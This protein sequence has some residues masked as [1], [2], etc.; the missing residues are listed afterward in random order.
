MVDY[1]L[2]LTKSGLQRP[3]LGEVYLLSQ[4]P[5][6]TSSRPKAD[7]DIPRSLDG[8]RC[9]S[10]EMDSSLLRTVVERKLLTE[11]RNVGLRRLDL[12]A[13]AIICCP[14]LH[15]TWVHIHGFS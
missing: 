9:G 5:E 15:C 4:P 14:G 10:S 8:L 3:F 12:S 2:L 1:T 13:T 6:R 7:S 11:S